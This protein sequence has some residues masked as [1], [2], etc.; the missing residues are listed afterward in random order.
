MTTEGVLQSWAVQLTALV[1]ILT[2][3]IWLA[4]KLWRII[5]LGEMAFQELIGTDDHPSLRKDISEVKALAARTDKELHP[6]GGGSIRDEVRALLNK[7]NELSGQAETAGRAALDAR[8]RAIILGER[9][10]SATTANR[11]RLAEVKDSVAELRQA[12]DASNSERHL[13]EEAYI[14]ALNHIGVPLLPI[15]DELEGGHT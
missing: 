11:E 2:A 9:L 15:A 8:E 7:Q 13:K 6:N 5:K 10:E 3:L 12:L 4:R 14:A 1:A